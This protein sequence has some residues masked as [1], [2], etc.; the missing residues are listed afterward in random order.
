MDNASTGAT[1]RDKV[2]AAFKAW[3]S[4]TG[5]ITEL[6]A[7]GIKWTIVGNSVASKTYESKQQFIDEVLHPF[8]QRFA[9]PFR[10]VT[11]RAIYEDGDTVIVLWDGEGTA[12]DSNPMRTPMPG[13]SRFGTA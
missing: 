9:T 12:L 2:A 5:Y 10:P 3:M 4:G 13:S 11:I 1:N 7:D 6:L 8:G